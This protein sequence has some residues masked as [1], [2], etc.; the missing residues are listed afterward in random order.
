MFLRNDELSKS[1][2]LKIDCQAAQH[3]IFICNVQFFI[4]IGNLTF[5]KYIGYYMNEVESYIAQ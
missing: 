3:D 4:F 5:G 1:F 2:F